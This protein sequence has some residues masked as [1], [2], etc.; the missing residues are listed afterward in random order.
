MCKAGT[1]KVQLHAVLSLSSFRREPFLRLVSLGQGVV[2][3]RGVFAC[4]KIYFILS[5]A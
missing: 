4:T 2:L 3:D 5:S 1:F